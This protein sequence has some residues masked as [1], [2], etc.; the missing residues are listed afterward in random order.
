MTLNFTIHRTKYKWQICLF[1]L[2]SYAAH[3]QQDAQFS[4]FNQNT[5]YNNPA[6]AGSSGRTQIQLAHRTQYIG[7]KTT[8]QDQGGAMSTQMLSYSMPIKNFGFGISA[9]NDQTTVRSNQ[10]IK[11]AAS[12]FIPAG[13]GKLYVGASAGIFRQSLDYDPLRPGEEE[14]PLLLTGKESEIKPDLNAGIQYISDAFHVGLSMTH[15]LKPQFSL[16]STTATNPLLPTAYLNA[17]VNLAVGYALQIQ[18]M[19]LVKSD[20]N[21]VSVE[22]GAT[23]TMK[24]TYWLG[25]TYRHQDSYIIA[26]AGIYLLQ[27][28]SLS[29]SGAYDFVASGKKEKSPSSFEVMLTYSLPNIKVGRKTII[30]TPRFRF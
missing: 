2:L 12:Y 18:P 17:G 9:I 22:G 10:D 26:M 6:T 19:A 24:D 11:L 14:D 21:T 13:D 29:L 4:L 30:R 20:L 25:A 5:L 27:D 8:N 1:M 23:F 28:Q 16:G 7:Y 15:L 3:A